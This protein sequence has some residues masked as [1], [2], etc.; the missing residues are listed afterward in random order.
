[1]VAAG[2]GWSWGTLWRRSGLQFQRLLDRPS[3]AQAEPDVVWVKTEGHFDQSTTITSAPPHAMSAY[4]ANE[5]LGNK[6]AEPLPLEIQ[7]DGTHKSA[8]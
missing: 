8:A 2:L 7:R 3:V 5:F 4:S 1:M 6:V